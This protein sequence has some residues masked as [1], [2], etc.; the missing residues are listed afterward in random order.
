MPSHTAVL[1]SPIGPIALASDGTAVTAVHLRVDEALRAPSDPVLR[2][3]AREIDEY[4]AGGRRCFSV[5][6]RRPAATAFQNRVWDELERIPF[7]ETVT[8]GELA[9]RLATSARAVGGA[10]AR[11]ALPLF[12]PCHRVVA[13]NGLGGFS[14]DWQTGMA[15]DVKAVLLAGER[16]ADDSTSATRS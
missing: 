14:G 10:C 5:P 16:G 1:P 15:V 3:A 4:F 7:G 8:Y 2:R 9:R 6:L 13:K 12:I 11:N